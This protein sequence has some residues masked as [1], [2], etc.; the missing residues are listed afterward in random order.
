MSAAK[1]FI[2]IIGTGPAGLGAAQ[3][4]KALGLDYLILEGAEA[5]FGHCKSF[6]LGGIVFDEGPHVSF[7]KNQR[8]QEM[9]AASAGDVI[10]LK[11][12]ML[13]YWRGSWIPHPVQTNLRDLPKDVSARI[14]ESMRRRPENDQ[15]ANYHEW[16]LSSFG[17]V[18]AA[19]FP[20]VYTEKYWT[21]HPS[22]LTTDWIGERISRPPLD[23]M[24]KSAGPA[25][26]GKDHHYFSLF[27]YPRQGGFQSFLKSSL[28]AH[29][30]R[31]HY[32][33]QVARVDLKAKKVVTTTG[34]A[35]SYDALITSQALDDLTGLCEISS[36]AG[37]ARQNLNCSAV[38]LYSITYRTEK[39]PP[40]HWLYIYDREIPFAR[41]HYPLTLQDRAGD[42]IQALQVEIYSS[43]YLPN[44]VGF[45]E[46]EP[47]LL[48]LERMGLLKRS[49]ILETDRRHCSHANVIFDHGR[50]N[51]AT[52]LL[53]ELAGHKVYPVGRF[54]KWA[55]LWSDESFV[56][57]ENTVNNFVKEFQ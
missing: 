25:V 32:S 17:E 38:T 49:D 35:Y 9:F 45:N 33:S 7:T 37:E 36:G 13:N 26:D 18:F 8:I 48:G 10:D 30:G 2:L 14:V 4:A 19:D 52:F 55:Y 22:K 43:K 31:I 5:P 28:A 6:T 39:R 20:Q 51:A 11:P 1:P 50:K 12:K 42:S 34:K 29:E 57:G 24:I 54:G 41:L 15:P 40:A 44:P 27:R 23:E 56:D 3:Q 16:L 46:L 53:S 21:V 47:I